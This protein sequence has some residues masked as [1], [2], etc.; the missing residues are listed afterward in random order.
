MTRR[1][2]LWLPL[3]VL[4]AYL[5]FFGDKTPDDRPAADVRETRFLSDDRSAKRVKRS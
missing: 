3:L 2:L 4:A 1:R 5:A